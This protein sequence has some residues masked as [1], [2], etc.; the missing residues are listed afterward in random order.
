MTSLKIK[1]ANEIA[2][3]MAQ[4]LGNEEFTS[5]FHKQAS[6]KKEAGP[7]LEAYKGDLASVTDKSGLEVAWNKHLPALQQEENVEEGTIQAAT[8][9]QAAK[10]QQLGLPGYQVP[11]CPEAQMAHDESCGCPEKMTEWEGVEEEEEEANDQ[12]AI[13]ADFT[14]GHLAKLANALDNQGFEKMAD[15]VDETMQKIAKKYKTWHGKGE[16]P[17]KGAAH[18]APKGWFD[19]MKDKVKKK[20]PDYS[21]KRIN[22]IVG[23]I[24][25]NKLSDAER[26]KIYK[27]HGKTKSPN[28]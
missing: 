15:M 6:F 14:L 2:E 23:D 21:A 26:E 20:N 17:P 19:E 28:K 18:K 5:V 16:K 24:W 25:D 11:G 9:A 22:E 12:F 13:A 8:C 10:A 4:A 27:R 7:A 1:Y 3:A